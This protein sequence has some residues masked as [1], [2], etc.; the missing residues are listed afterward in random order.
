MARKSETG[1]TEHTSTENAALA[2]LEP[3]CETC[4]GKG[5][6]Q[7]EGESGPDGKPLFR[8]CRVCDGTGYKFHDPI[9]DHLMDIFTRFLEMT[10][11]A[12]VINK[13]ID[14]VFEVGSEM[15]RPE[16][17]RICDACHRELKEGQYLRKRLCPTCAQDWYDV[18]HK[19]PENITDDENADRERFCRQKPFWSGHLESVCEKCV[20]AAIKPNDDW[21]IDQIKVLQERGEL[22]TP[23]G[24][25]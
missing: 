14:V 9:A 3:E 21:R 5:N 24:E 8:T 17:S 19:D 10:G 6:I 4:G 1:Y 16:T 11:H 23:R 18:W 25:N 2:M 12:T 20:Q 15:R 13:K 22:P 7:I